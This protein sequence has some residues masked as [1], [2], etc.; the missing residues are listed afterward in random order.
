M[1]DIIEAGYDQIA[2]T[3]LDW[4][5]R[6]T[7]EARP[8]MLA[9]LM[10]R[11]GGR[12]QVLELGCGAGIPCTQR[13]AERHDVFGVDL[14]S[15]QLDLA[16]RNV[17][18]ARFVKADMT[19]LEFEPGTFDAVAAFYS[20]LHVPRAEQPALFRTVASWLRPGGM[21][22]AALGSGTDDVHTT[23]LGTPMFFGSHRPDVNRSL[24]A[25]AGFTL[26]VDEVVTMDE[27][28]GPATFHW[29][30]GTV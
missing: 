7:D 18:G 1:K 3:Y 16:R 11:L 25:E 27:P 24:L 10:D 26:L 29:V 28:E 5:G 2:Q 9:E 8:R 15:A 12:S 30:I 19:S 14:S 21:F 22:L 13:L 6:F 4:C 17:P 23:W 20:I